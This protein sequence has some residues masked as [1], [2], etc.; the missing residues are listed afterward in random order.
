ITNGLAFTPTATTTYTVTGTIDAT[1]CKAT[2]MVTVTVNPLPTVTAPDD[3]STCEETEITLT[4]TG[5]ADEFAWDNEVTNDV[6]FTSSVTT[7]YTVTG[8]IIATGCHS[9]DRVTVSVN[10]IPAAIINTSRESICENET[11]NVTITAETEATTLQ[12]LF[13]GTPIDGATELTHTATA[14]GEY[15]LSAS[16]DGCA[17]ISNVLTITP[18]EAPVTSLPKEI[19]TITTADEITLDAGIGFVTYLWD[20]NSNEQTRLVNGKELDP[21]TYILW[22]EV[23]NEA[24]CLTRDTVKVKVDPYQSVATSNGLAVELYPNPTRGIVKIKVDNANGN[25]TISIYNQTGQLIS[26]M[27]SMVQ[28]KEILD[29]ANLSDLAKGI[30]IIQVATKNQRITKLIVL[31]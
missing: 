13:N 22:V 28:G 16:K 2:N 6:A 21:N 11:V 30:Y 10:P 29:E 14:F 31:E 23:T 20:N 27:Q 24:G 19:I 25:A 5:D 9:T 8:T 15:S 26:K 4:A 17:C 7:T 18:V 3:F 12:W 1:G